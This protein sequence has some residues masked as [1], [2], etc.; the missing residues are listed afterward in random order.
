MKDFIHQF[1]CIFTSY[2]TAKL[3]EAYKTKHV[4]AWI[5]LMF[6]AGPDDFFCLIACKMLVIILLQ[7][8]LLQLYGNQHTLQ[9][10]YIACVIQPQLS[11][12]SARPPPGV[13][14]RLGIPH[15]VHLKKKWQE[16]E[17]KLA[18][19]ACKEASGRV[20]EHSA[21]SGYVHHVYKQQ[22]T[23]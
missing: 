23:S 1:L 19:R 7:F 13:R 21:L 4:A 9:G 10:G 20:R 16:K 22:Y 5:N 15:I 17:Q 11:V 18:A 14:L 3:P 2:N 8:C 6:F 12:L